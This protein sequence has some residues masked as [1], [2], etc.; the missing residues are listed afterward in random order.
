MNPAV[1]HAWV[2]GAQPQ[3]LSCV[4]K[5]CVAT[6]VDFQW[7]LTGI[8]KEHKSPK[9]MLEDL[10]DFENEPRLSGFFHIETKRL[11]PKSIE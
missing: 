3:N 9:A 6:D 8:E 1:V 7:L 2:N 4:L 5:L 10:F 11:I